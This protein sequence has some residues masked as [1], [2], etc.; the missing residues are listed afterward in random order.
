MLDKPDTVYVVEGRPATVTV[1]FNH[2]EA[3]VVWRR[4]GPC[5][6][7]R[8]TFR[9]L[10]SSSGHPGLTSLWMDLGDLH[11]MCPLAAEGPC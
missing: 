8:P 2:V 9:K 3:Q 11:I 4:W 5:L 1:T 6:H 10:Q 7:A